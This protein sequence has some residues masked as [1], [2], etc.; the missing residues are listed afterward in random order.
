MRSS[1]DMLRR[2]S[3]GLELPHPPSDDFPYPHAHTHSYTQASLTDMLCS[4][5][6]YRLASSPAV[7]AF[8]VFHNQDIT[9]AQF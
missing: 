7:D 1:K 9:L 3:C 5:I 4:C 6:C 2:R 8:E